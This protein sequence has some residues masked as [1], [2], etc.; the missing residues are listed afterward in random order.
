MNGSANNDGSDY[1]L[2]TSSNTISLKDITYT[3]VY[4]FDINNEGENYISIYDGTDL[5]GGNLKKITIAKDKNITGSNRAGEF[6]DTYTYQDTGKTVKY[7][8]YIVDE[9]GSTSIDGNE[10][11]YIIISSTDSSSILL[12]ES[13]SEM[14]MTKDSLSSVIGFDKNI[15]TKGAILK[16]LQINDVASLDI[17]SSGYID[18]SNPTIINVTAN[19]FIT[20]DLIASNSLITLSKAFSGDTRYIPTMIITSESDINSGRIYWKALSPVQ[21]MSRWYNEY[22]LFSTNNQKAYWVYL[23]DY[24]TENPIQ[25]LSGDGVP[26][27]EVPSVTKKYI[28][29]FDNE[30]NITH[31]YFNI[32]KVKA[33]VKGVLSNEDG[34]ADTQSVY[35]V[36]NLV[37]VSPTIEKL[38][39]KMPMAS[40]SATTAPIVDGTMEFSTAINYFDVE[41]LNNNLSTIRITATDGRLYTDEYLLP[42][43]VKKPSKPVIS[44]SSNEL[45]PAESTK[46]FIKSGDLGTANDDTIKYLIFK[47]RIDD[48]NGTAFDETQNIPSNFILSVDKATGEVGVDE[49][50][51]SSKFAGNNL[52]FVP[53][54]VVALDNENISQANFSD[55]TKVN[56]IPMQNVHVL[57]D[58]DVASETGVNSDLYPNVYDAQCNAIGELK[59]SNGNSKDSGVSLRSLSGDITLTYKPF[60]VTTGTTVQNSMIIG[61]K[62]GASTQ[63]IAQIKYEKAYENK[64]FFVYKDGNLYKGL[65][66]NS[67]E[68][69]K[70]SHDSNPYTLTKISSSGQ[71]IGE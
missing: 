5:T 43:D 31:N 44:F 18:F 50:C 19:P 32:S 8:S 58:S 51:K 27:T 36:A 1:I 47:D 42:I 10:S 20:D 29:T 40:S 56:F 64:N 21:K 22:N 52:D 6:N 65:F 26:E 34:K 25:I 45:A 33:N 66:L 12:I 17:N 4:K 28:R 9:N 60:D 7:T 16:G 59:D 49:L 38:D 14:N 24:P 13:V 23:D 30:N 37:G 39:F 3:K 63:A 68:S 11:E 67:S 15:S 70:Y 2:L 41:G 35:V 48:I 57:V 54:V 71:K 55:M 53:I 62:N 69:E 46:L 61:V